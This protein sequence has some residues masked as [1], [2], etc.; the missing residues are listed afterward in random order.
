MNTELRNALV[1]I[2][3]LQRTLP[4]I[5]MAQCRRRGF[6]SRHIE[7]RAIIGGHAQ[8]YDAY[9]TL[10][11][12]LGEGFLFIL[13]G[14]R[15]GGKTQIATSLA[16]DEIERMK[17][18]WKRYREIQWPLYSTARGL[19][20]EIRATYGNSDSDESQI[21]RRFV[22]PHLLVIDETQERGNTEWEDMALTDIIDK[23]YGMQRDTIIISN[24]T[25][26]E[27]PAALGPSIIS[28]LHET[29]EVIECNWPSFREKK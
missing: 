18:F 8:C 16:C 21:L 10:R 5:F 23:R 22:E 17:L 7:H 26:A 13:C 9:D 15:G 28:R 19:F 27:L 3:T 4:E 11:H 2:T 6:L 20:L 12:R 14:S 29:G 24:L 1:S 25:R